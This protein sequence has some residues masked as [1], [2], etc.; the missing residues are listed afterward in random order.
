MATGV[1]VLITR[2]R[3]ECSQFAMY[4]FCS[5]CIQ[6]VTIPRCMTFSMEYMVLGYYCTWCGLCRASNR[7]MTRTQLG[8]NLCWTGIVYCVN[9]TIIIIIIIVIIIII[10]IISIIIIIINVIDII[11]IIVIIIIIIIIILTLLFNYYCYT[12]YFYV[13]ILSLL[14]FRCL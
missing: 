3:A 8:T 1:H 2:Y 7:Q 5:V 11:I 10:T 9:I 6:I 14:L 4:L 13:S 12:H